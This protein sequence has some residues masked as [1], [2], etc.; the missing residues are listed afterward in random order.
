MLNVI[1]VA[2]TDTVMSFV[3]V[4]VPEL[5]RELLPRNPKEPDQIWSFASERPAEDASKVPPVM[6]REPD[7]IAVAKPKLR[8]PLLSVVPPV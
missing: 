4:I 7:P 8:I 6:V 3:R 1:L 2:T 5:E